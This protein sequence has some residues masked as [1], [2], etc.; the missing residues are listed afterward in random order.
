MVGSGR[1]QAT[2]SDQVFRDWGK[3][4]RHLD[5]RDKATK[6]ERNDSD[7]KEKE[8]TDSVPVFPKDRDRSRTGK[9]SRVSL[10][11]AFKKRCNTRCNGVRPVCL[12]VLEGRHLRSGN[13]WIQNP[14]GVNLEWVQVPPLALLLWEDL[15][16]YAVCPCL[17]VAEP[18]VPLLSLRTV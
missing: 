4:P 9:D 16:R 13:D 17:V 5:N 15:R 10:T 18:V 11:K 3:S 14:V 1:R 7:V 2:L 8:K 12:K 6:T